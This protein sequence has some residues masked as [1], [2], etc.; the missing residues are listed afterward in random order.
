MVF[1]AKLSGEAR[2]EGPV[3]VVAS[4]RNLAMDFSEGE[5]SE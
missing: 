3:Y 2:D 1:N 5:R 4:F